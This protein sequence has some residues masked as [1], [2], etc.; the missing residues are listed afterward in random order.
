M[1]HHHY[2]NYSVCHCHH[3]SELA[4]KHKVHTQNK[5]PKVDIRAI[6]QTENTIIDLGLDSHQVVSLTDL[7][8]EV[9]RVVTSTI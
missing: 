5:F 6:K 9:L 8:Y 4:I 7:Y 2:Q 1:R 3:Q